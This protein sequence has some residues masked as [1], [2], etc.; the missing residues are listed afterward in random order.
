MSRVLEL[1]SERCL[2]FDED[3]PRISDPSGGRDL[4]EE[5][6]GERATMIVVPATRLD[7]SF[8]Q[9]RS[10]LAGEIL[11]KAVNYSLKFAVLGNIA[12]HVAASD[13]LRDFVYE[14]NNGR[15]I[16]F[17]PDEQALEQRLT[18]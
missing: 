15:Q 8:F 5:A 16:W 9:L 18:T 17:L 12:D 2:I 10:G 1:G 11:Q 7:P 4:I 14:S 3:G 6:M 13:A